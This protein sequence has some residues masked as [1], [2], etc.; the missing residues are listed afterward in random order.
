MEQE[1]DELAVAHATR[2][3]WR[4]IEMLSVC[5]HRADEAPQS[6]AILL[7]QITRRP[8]LH[9]PQFYAKP[10]IWTTSYHVG[11][12]LSNSRQRGTYISPR[13]VCVSMARWVIAQIL[14]I[15]P[16]GLDSPLQLAVG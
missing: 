12:L 3:H 5:K 14:N 2:G 7:L 4:T 11:E 10:P 15:S 16:S 8:P 6:C 13:L 1:S 9:I